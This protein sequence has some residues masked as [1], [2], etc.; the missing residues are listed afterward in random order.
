MSD[1]P[2]ATGLTEVAGIR[3]TYGIPNSQNQHEVVSR[4]DQSMRGGQRRLLSRHRGSFRHRVLSWQDTIDEE[5]IEGVG[6]K[7][8]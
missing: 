1:I 3:I 8:C 6:A 4:F 5:I 2:T 7:G